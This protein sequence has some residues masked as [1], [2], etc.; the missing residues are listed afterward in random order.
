MSQFI[1]S[2]KDK[3]STHYI[4]K[5]AIPKIN[6]K[7]GAVVVILLIILAFAFLLLQLKDEEKTNKI[8]ECNSNTEC[9]PSSCCHP[10]SCAPLAQS[11]ECAGIICTQ[12]CKPG[13]LDCNQAS[14]QC[15][16]NKCQ[17]VQ[18]E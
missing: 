12:E 18:N 4:F 13:T 7:K 15:I 1:P 16:N 8:I 14:C 17:V 5:P 9:V 3:R 10:S 11:P 6:M 2:S